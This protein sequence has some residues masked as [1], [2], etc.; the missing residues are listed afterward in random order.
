MANIAT[1]IQII[2]FKL[3]AEEY[4]LEISGVQEII[5]IQ[6]ITRVP[7]SKPYILGV[8]N[9][10][11]II[12]PVIDL[13]IRFGIGKTTE[14]EKKRVIILKFGTLSVGIVVDGVSE[15][16]DVSASQILS[17]PAITSSMNQEFLKGV[18]KLGDDRLLTLLDIEK[19][20]EIKA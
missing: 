11:G 2:G 10:R 7:R 16:I 5:K 15:V 9:L 12:I 6:S 18:C 19:T 1:D 17:N 13:N 20:L 4:A 3:N 8:I 14:I